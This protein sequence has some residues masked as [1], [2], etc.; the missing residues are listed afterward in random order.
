[1][2]RAILCLTLGTF[3]TALLLSLFSVYILHDVDREKV[4]HLNQ[5]FT[6]LCFESAVFAL[7]IGAAT[8]VLTAIGKRLLR[9]KGSNS[10]PAF[11]IFLGCCVAVCQYPWDLVARSFFPQLADLALETYVVVASLLC[12][13]VL[14]RRGLSQDKAEIDERLC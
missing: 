8:G 12:A 4:G 5:A 9:V 1:M 13:A 14:L 10:R 3:S 7:V 2:R 11:G 6:G